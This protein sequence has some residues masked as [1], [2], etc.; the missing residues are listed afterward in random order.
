MSLV[1]LAH[2]CSHLQ[3]AS[4]AR[5]SLTS[6][7]HTKLHLA[8]AHQLQKAGFLSVVTIGGP[9]PPLESPLLAHPPAPTPIVRQ[10]RWRTPV[11]DVLAF[12]RDGATGADGDGNLA[13]LE[14]DG[15]APETLD[16]R[17]L[18]E[19]ILQDGTA[20]RSSSAP[21][22]EPEQTPQPSTDT[23]QKRTSTPYSQRR[24]IQQVLRRSDENIA[25]ISQTLSLLS[26]AATATP[27][28]RLQR[29][30]E[31]ERQ[32]EQRTLVPA[33]VA[34]RRLWLGLKY[35]ENSLV[36]CWMVMV[37]KT[38]RGIW[39]GN[40]VVGNLML[41]KESGYVKGLRQVGECMFVST[42]RGVMELREAV[43]RKLG[44]MLL[45]RAL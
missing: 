35:W 8:I 40:D 41:V 45:C 9:N 21:D 38:S 32:P 28:Q 25:H 42:D 10:H 18:W 11:T 22:F 15:A 36:L 23:P 6:F 43:E 13:V 26:G 12:I 5:L 30:P 19:N 29:I 1:H 44:G 4:R 2:L 37:C 17:H 16:I 7:P 27:P 34:Q 20:P 3:N 14:N 33:N 31:H 24:R 39:M